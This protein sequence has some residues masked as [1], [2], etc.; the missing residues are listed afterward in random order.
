MKKIIFAALL[1]LSA[2]ASADVVWRD[3]LWGHKPALWNW[4]NVDGSSS[5]VKHQAGILRA[6]R[7][8]TAAAQPIH[9]YDSANPNSIAVVISTFPASMAVGMYEF[10]VETSSGIQVNIPNTGGPAIT[11]YYR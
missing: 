3:D 6:M 5:T 8:R 2:S 10:N 1:F 7:I 4:V 11:L 9:I